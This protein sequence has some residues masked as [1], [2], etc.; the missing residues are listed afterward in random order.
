VHVATP[1]DAGQAPPSE[2][3]K[4][5]EQWIEGWIVEWS[6]YGFTFRDKASGL[7]IELPWDVLSQADIARVKNRGMVGAAA[8]GDGGDG[9]DALAAQARPK[10][11]TVTAMRCIMEGG[12]QIVGLPL[13]DESTPEIIYIRTRNA[14]KFPV[15]RKEVLRTE[16]VEV[17]ET[18]VYS[19]DDIYVMLLAKMNPKTGKDHYDIAE[20]LMAVGNYERAREHY[21]R[22]RLMEERLADNV[23][24]KMEEID[25]FQ[26]Q[27]VNRSYDELINR[28]IRAGRIASALA[29]IGQ[30][31]KI[32]PD[33]PIYTN[34]VAQ[35]P[36]LREELKKNMR[37]NI[38]SAYYQKMEEL[39]RKF[40]QNRVPDEEAIPA[41]VITIKGGQAY[42]GRL[43]EDGE[44]YVSI[45]DS[46]R[47]L[48]I[49][50]SQIAGMT[51]TTI[52]ASKRWPTFAESRQYVADASGGITADILK[53]LE[54]AFRDMGVT[55]ED[56][57]GYWKDRTRSVV[58]IGQSGR[59]VT[60][61]VSSWHDAS[62]SSG[63]WLRAGGGPVVVTTTGSGGQSGGIET[64]PERWWAKQSADARYTVLRAFAGEALCEAQVFTTNCEMC[65]GKGGIVVVGGVLSPG[66]T[67]AGVNMCPACRG[68]GKVINIRY[69]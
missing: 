53:E 46:G 59:K 23:A 38:V 19:G 22:A 12:H 57:E 54:E 67:S 55:R 11:A 13:E 14:R 2:R 51:N 33:S 26:Q 62:Y 18:E 44:E 8:V 9:E 39:I 69:R 15:H 48:R 16:A 35:M 47:E 56:I 60:P 20:Y 25:I 40:A 5:N 36:R 58:E 4:I 30:L 17:P 1:A 45:E 32:D 65:G 27:E 24:R 68:S 63:S 34:W 28:D 42:T 49:A 52:V 50:R 3:Y 37:K 31:G 64:D 66:G 21:E 43:I 7:D 61:A 29:R 6:E 10:V 41:V